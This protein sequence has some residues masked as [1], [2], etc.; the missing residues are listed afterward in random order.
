MPTNSGPK[1]LP[2][3][4]SRV[5]NIALHKRS[6]IRKLAK[7][8]GVAKSSLHRWFKE[9]QLRH[10]S[11]FLKPSVKVASNKKER[12][13]WCLSMLDP[14]NLPNEPKFIEM[15]NIIYIDEKWFNA[16]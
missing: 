5:A 7:A 11:N 12:L 16:T 15:D 10:H 2:V 3:D 8:L 14:S 4:L 9:G 1:R 6:T 13:R